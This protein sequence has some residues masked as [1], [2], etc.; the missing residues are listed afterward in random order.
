M[1]DARK[2]A[3]PNAP[4]PGATVAF[5]AARAEALAFLAT[6]IQHDLANP[7]GAILA[8]ASYLASDPRLPDD[9][10]DDARLLREEADRTHRIVR[11]LLDAA[12][13]TPNPA[14]TATLATAVDEILELE[15]FALRGVRVE[16]AIPS[17]LPPVDVDSSR[18]RHLLL[19]LTVEAIRRLGD[20]HGGS[21]LRIT[22]RTIDEHAAL[23]VGYAGVGQGGQASPP[24][25]SIAAAAEVARSLGG[26]LR[27]DDT[28][29]GGTFE[30]RLP[31]AVG[32]VGQVADDIPGATVLPPIHAPGPRPAPVVLVCD[33]EPSIRSL[34]VRVLHREGFGTLVASSGDEA[35][36]LLRSAPVDVVLTDQHMEGMSGVELFERAA[37]DDPEGRPPFVVM[38]GEP[39]ADD[40]V[41]LA[42]RPD[43]T[44]LPKPFETAPVAETIR[45]VVDPEGYLG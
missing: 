7:L 15:D 8:F 44:V 41:R 27:V 12:R 36:A 37:V 40:V 2:P 5:D 43:V 17:D 45:E 26:S 23:V 30:L 22:A 28:G 16:R 21:Q 19:V 18:L 38:T 10:R 3:V 6:G 25:P 20:P 34:L 31:L 9:L 42:E 35:L 13:D 1:P 4:G 39:D 11:A 24:S 29:D 33:D 32:T 14:G